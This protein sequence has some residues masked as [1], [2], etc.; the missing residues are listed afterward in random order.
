MLNANDSYLVYTDGSCW[1][2]DR[3]GAFA[4]IAIDSKG[5]EVLEGGSETDTTSSRMEL[6]APIAALQYILDHCGPSVCLIQSDSEYVVLGITNR[7]RNRKVN[8][9]LWNALD[10]VVDDHELVAFEHV[11]GHNGDHYNEMVDD[12]AGE[13]RKAAQS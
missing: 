13:L 1:H 8:P 9:D 2:G 10:Q 12:L 7:Y 3:V 11:K 4:W 5:N 6:Q